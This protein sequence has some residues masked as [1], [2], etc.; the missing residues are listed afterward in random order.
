MNAL[1]LWGGVECT[2]NRV[3]DRFFDQMNASGHATRL[4]DLDRFAS[5]GMKAIRYPILWERLAPCSLRELDWRWADERL[6]RIR[7]LD[8]KAIVG[9]VHHGSGPVY[10]SLIDDR[11]AE[12]LATYARAVAERF[13]WIEDWTPVNEPL[14]TARFSGLYGHW[15]PHARDHRPF[16]RALVNQLRGVWLAMRE[17]RA[18]N[19]AARLV[20][21]EDLSRTSGTSRLKPEIMLERQR[22]WLTWDLLSGRIVPTHPLYRFLRDGGAL[23]SELAAFSDEPCTPDVLGI[24]YYLT[25]DRWLDDR[26]DAYPPWSH[27]GN[28]RIAY[29]DVEAVRARPRGI[30]GHEQH[31]LAAWRRYRRPVALTEVHLGCTREEQMRWLLTAWRGAEAARARGAEVCAVTAWAL[32]GSHDW[33][34]LVTADRGYY[35]PGVFDIRAPAPRETALAAVARDLAAGRAPDHPVLRSDGWWR[36]PGRLSLGP[37]ACGARASGAPSGSPILV[38]GRR[39]TLGGAFRRICE[40]RGLATHVV[41]RAEM[42]I[43]NPPGI[44]AVIRR[45]KPWAVVNAAG[46]V[47]ID[48]AEADRKACWSDNVEGPVNLAAACR[49][50]RLPLV[51]FSSDQVFDGGARVPYTEDD[52][53]APLNA[54]GTAKA[55]AEGRVLALMPE[56]L[57]V[58]TSAFFGPWDEYNFATQ[59]LRNVAGGRPFLAPADNTVSPTYVPDLVHATLDLLIDGERGIWHLA[60][61]G[62]VTWLDFGRMVARVSGLDEGLVEPCSWRDIWGPAARPQ[63]SALGSARGHLLPALERSVEVYAAETAEALAAAA[64]GVRA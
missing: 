27:G 54:Y 61:Q 57:I 49:R 53:P 33:S 63:Y 17:I 60:N 24:N 13:P 56:A 36:R 25:S 20:Q 35:E 32:L 30:V 38:I 16:V 48:A 6:L 62:E 9:L 28:D 11:F 34:T 8:M 58:R 10:T 26:L 4:D 64:F 14:T 3:G 31:L 23:E 19:P 40:S 2:V 47:S 12:S 5:L 41:G 18:V 29:A 39:G 46:Y 55:E 22:R 45:V 42:D 1:E 51:T 59:A 44:D 43:C 52:E 50:H 21:T 15:Y 7:R 37:A